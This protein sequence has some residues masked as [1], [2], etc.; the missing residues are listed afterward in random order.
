MAAYEESPA[1]VRLLSFEEVGGLTLPDLR[2]ALRARGVS[3]AG[4][5]ETLVERLR[6]V[7]TEARAG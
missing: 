6:K 7:L 2:I 3:P 1:T 5:K 4:S